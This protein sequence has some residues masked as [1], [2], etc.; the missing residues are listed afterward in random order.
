MPSCSTV[1]TIR[2]V[3]RGP[4][5]GV[6]RS[7]P[8]LRDVAPTKRWSPAP[9]SLNT[10]RW[11]AIRRARQLSTRAAPPPRTRAATPGAGSPS[12]TATPVTALEPPSTLTVHVP[13]RRLAHEHV[14]RHPRAVT[15][16]HRIRRRRVHIARNADR[17]PARLGQRHRRGRVGAGHRERRDAHPRP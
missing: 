15:Q 14:R 3:P 5:A 16:R 7:R 10:I 6:N 8:R 11:P 12:A 4:S 13:P 9:T 2:R 17:P 1:A